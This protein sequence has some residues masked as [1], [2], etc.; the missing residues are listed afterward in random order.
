[1]T[2]VKGQRP[3]NKGLTRKT[4]KRVDSYAKKISGEKNYA[5]KGDDVSYRELH[6]WVERYYGKPSF[7]E[8]CLSGKKKLYDWANVSGEYKRDRDDWIR[9]CRGCHIKF[10]RREK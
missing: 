9:L 4:D 1:M 6:K 7:C 8:H 5:W 3:W 10:D 2:F